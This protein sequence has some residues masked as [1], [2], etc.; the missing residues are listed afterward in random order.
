MDGELPDNTRLVGSILIGGVWLLLIAKL[1]SPQ[2]GRWSD[3]C[4]WAG[5]ICVGLAIFMVVRRKIRRWQ[6]KGRKSS[7]STISR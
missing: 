6:G 7:V 3:W 4:L 2:L 5:W 1:F